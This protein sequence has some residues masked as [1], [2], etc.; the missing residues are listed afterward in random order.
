MRTVRL[1]EMDRI[2]D[3]VAVRGAVDALE[4]VTN[5]EDFDSFTALGRAIDGAISAASYLAAPEI[6]AEDD[7]DEPDDD[8]DDDEPDEAVATVT[9]NGWSPGASQTKNGQRSTLRRPH[10]GH[11]GCRPNAWQWAQGRSPRRPAT[12]SWLRPR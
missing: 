12:R 2:S 3:S 10:V 5:R 7:D 6:H 8:A 11:A 1:R 9:R 4:R